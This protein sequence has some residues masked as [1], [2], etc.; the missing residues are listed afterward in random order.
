[1][2]LIWNHCLIT[3]K[4]QPITVENEE[5]LLMKE[6]SEELRVT[7]ATTLKYDRVSEEVETQRDWKKNLGFS[8]K[9]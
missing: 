2:E 1:M 3:A 5:E 7:K 9:I 4:Y 6:P 8:I